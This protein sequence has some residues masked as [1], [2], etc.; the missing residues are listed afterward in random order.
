MLTNMAE[1]LTFDDEEVTAL[2]A[3][4][5][6][7]GDAALSKS[8]SQLGDWYTLV[9]LK[10]TQVKTILHGAVLTEYLRSITAP[11]GLIVSNEPRI[12]LEDLELKKDW[13]LIAWK[14]KQRPDCLKHS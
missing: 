4:P 11:N 1:G 3:A 10:R 6:L 2:L 12:F 9:E 7:L 5:S 14:L 8:L 13:A